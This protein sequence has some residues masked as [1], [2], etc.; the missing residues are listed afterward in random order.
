MNDQ[1]YIR[2]AVDLVDNFDWSDRGYNGIWIELPDGSE[3]LFQT[4][5]G[6]VVVSH[7]YLQQYWLD[8]LAAQLVR[9][10]DALDTPDTVEITHD[11]VWVG[12]RS[13]NNESWKR[14]R[15]TKSRD[16]TMNTIKAIVDSG[17]LTTGDS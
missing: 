1:D 10:V 9:Q 13:K 4:H 3:E 12:Y 17:V 8:A 5:Q 7:P 11:S 15:R 6:I 16:R 2:K 14:T